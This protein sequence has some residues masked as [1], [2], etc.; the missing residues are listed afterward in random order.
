MKSENC[1]HHWPTLKLGPDYRLATCIFPKLC[2]RVGGDFRGGIH[3][4]PE[5]LVWKIAKF[6]ERHCMP[7]RTAPLL[8]ILKW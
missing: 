8:D 3:G 4:D 6:K 7:G 1:P 2:S 5:S